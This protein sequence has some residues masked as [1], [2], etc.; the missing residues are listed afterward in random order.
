MLE[1]FKTNFPGCIVYS[2]KGGDPYLVKQI[3]EDWLREHAVRDVL[4]K[5]EPY[6][7]GICDT[8]KS[9]QPP[10]QSGES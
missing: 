10:T 9:N 6:L 8:V 5:L 1:R 7:N 2:P 3:D 4:C